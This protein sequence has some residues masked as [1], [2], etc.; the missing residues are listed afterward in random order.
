MLSIGAGAER[1]A[2]A[3]IER[4]GTR[5]VVRAREDVQ[6]RGARRRSAR[7]RSGCRCATSR[8]SQEAVPGRRVR[9]AAGR[10]RAVQDPRRRRARPKRRCSASATATR[11]LSPFALAEGRFID[12]R[13]ELRP[14]AGLRDRG[15]RPPR[16]V[17]RRPRARQGRQD[18]RRLV[19]GRSACS[20]ARP[21][22]VSAAV[23]GVAVVVDRARDLHPVHDRA[24]QARPRPA[25]VAAVG[26]RRPARAR[27]RRP[28]RPAR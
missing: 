26:D 16:S 12:Q 14:R 23:Q 17:R 1:Q 7:S 5:N 25:E 13:D 6:A 4:L 20:R 24:A 21:T 2:L 18:Q 19:R 11:E 3:L 22:A 27:R 8:R 10:D 28:A 15:R 9:G